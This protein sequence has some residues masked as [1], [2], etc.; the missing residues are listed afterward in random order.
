[1]A[2][3]DP[4]SRAC[5]QEL[6]DASVRRVLQVGAGL[7]VALALCVAGVGG[8]IALYQRHWQARQAPQ[9]ALQR[10]PLVPPAPRLETDP[11]AEGERILAEARQRLGS[12]GWQARD[13]GIARIPIERAK[14]LLVERGWPSDAERRPGEPAYPQAESRG[15]RGKDADD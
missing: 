9:T 2:D 3:V 7:L 15:Q 12:Y 13:G 6:Q 4:R 14:A 11:P 1:M 8:L 10:E 5:G